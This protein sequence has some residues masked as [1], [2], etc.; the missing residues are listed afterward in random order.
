[1]NAGAI[2]DSLLPG[3]GTVELRIA[4]LSGN[5]LF[6]VPGHT[7]RIRPADMQPIGAAV[8]PSSCTVRTR[9]A[10]RPDGRR[11]KAI[12][13]R[14]LTALAGPAGRALRIRIDAPLRRTIQRAG[15]ATATITFDL[16]DATGAK[17]RVVA[18]LRLLPRR[19][20]G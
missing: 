15:G 11:G 8:C 18:K 20:A 12:R 10:I 4:G 2:A 13:P 5:R 7:A 1:M 6:V 17:T 19:T 9:A 14:R 16:Y 3:R